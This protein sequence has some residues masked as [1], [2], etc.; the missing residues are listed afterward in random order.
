MTDRYCYICKKQAPKFLSQEWNE[1]RW[2]AVCSGAEIE[3]VFCPEHREE[4]NKY[5]YETPHGLG[6]LNRG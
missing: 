5:L 6:A 2:V 4:G 3:A 1:K